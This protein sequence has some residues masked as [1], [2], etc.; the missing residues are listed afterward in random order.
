MTK[1]H[2][3]TWLPGGIYDQLGGG[4]HSVLRRSLAWLVPHFEKMLY[5]N[6]QLA[7]AYAHAAAVTGDDRYAYVARETLDFVAHELR[8]PPNGAFASSLDA[9]TDGV[10]GATYTW[11]AGE[12]REILGD[13]SPL[14]EQAY[15]VTDRGNWEGTTILSRVRDDTALAVE[16]E[17]PR[18]EIAE[19]LTTARVALLRA[20]DTRPQPARDDKVLTSWNGLMIG[21]FA[22]GGVILGEP[23][24][25]EVAAEAARFVA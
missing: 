9:D 2:S 17:R 14:F 7:R 11:R 6:A 22:D 15:G 23:G 4:F 10:E 24:F 19:A 25:I 20:R 13:E 8:N 3:T 18:D 5:D 21:A 12:I 16:H 1:T